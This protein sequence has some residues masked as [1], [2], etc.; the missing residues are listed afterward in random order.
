[1]KILFIRH[2]ESVDDIEDRYGGWSDYDLTPKGKGQI[3]KRVQPINEL[4]IKFDK[5]YYSPLKRAALSAGILSNSLKV[6]NEQFEYVKER[7]T[8]GLLSGMTKSEAKEKYPDQVDALEK[9][10][11]VDGSERYEDL[12]SRVKKSIDLVKK[13]NHKAIIVVTHG[14][15]L[16]CLFAEFVG[17][18]LIRKEDGGY[19]LMELKGGKLFPLESSGIEYE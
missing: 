16:K 3:S 10:E 7:N 13:L 6:E 5:I 4:N 11:Y 8:Y 17:N 9:G 18:K 12:T 14:N 19:V 15:Y 2:G 1:M